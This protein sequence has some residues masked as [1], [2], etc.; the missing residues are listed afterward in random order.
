MI[1]SDGDMSTLAN[2]KF[3]LEMN[4]L[5]AE[6]EASQGA[7]QNLNLIECKYLPWESASEKLL[8]IKP[9]IVLGADVIYDP[10]SVPHLIHL[11]AILLSPKRFSHHQ[12]NERCYKELLENHIDDET[13]DADGKALNFD[14]NNTHEHLS[15]S[16][17]ATFQWSNSQKGKASDEKVHRLATN[18][19][20][21]NDNDISN[22]FS[23]WEVV[24]QGP[25]AYIATVIRNVDTFNYFLTL[26]E[27]ARLSVVDLTETGKPLNLLPYMR[28]YD[29]SSIRLYAI[30]FSCN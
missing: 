2:M 24:K 20:K 22:G 16:N 23:I 27:K 17:D 26:A 3:N 12:G 15:K 21:A 25:V 14:H 1:L 18:Q 7:F 10:M 19:D 8:D 30:S 6:M 9:D 11:L 13:N 29:R 28:S 4:R 5:N